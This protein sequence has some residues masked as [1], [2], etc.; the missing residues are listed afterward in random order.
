MNYASAFL[1]LI[2]I[3]AAIY[4]YAGGKRFYTGPLIETE[5]ADDQS[6]S[7]GA[8]HGEKDKPEVK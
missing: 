7:S 1:A 6:T 5:V 3:A 4:W 8:L 2:L